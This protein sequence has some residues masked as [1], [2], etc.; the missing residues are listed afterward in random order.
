MT[1]CSTSVI[2]GSWPGLLRSICIV[3]LFVRIVEFNAS[4]SHSPLD[5]KND[6][7]IMVFCSGREKANRL[8][9]L[10]LHLTL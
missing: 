8:Y 7:L 9:I 6:Y 3:V 5:L 10:Y 4:R 2:M 1:G